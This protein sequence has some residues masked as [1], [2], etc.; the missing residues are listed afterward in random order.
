[1]LVSTFRTSRFMWI[2]AVQQLASSTVLYLSPVQ[3]MPPWKRRDGAN[4]HESLIGAGYP[5]SKSLTVNHRTC[6]RKDHHK[7]YNHR[8]MSRRGLLPRSHYTNHILLSCQ[9]HSRK[10]DTDNPH[11]TL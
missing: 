3:T 1:M 11:R 5:V 7:T 10:K 6:A 8:D 2:G 9:N 4:P